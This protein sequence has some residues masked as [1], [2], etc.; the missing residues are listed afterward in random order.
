MKALHFGAG[1]IG[2]GFIGAALVKSGYS[3]VFADTAAELVAHINHVGSY[4]VHVVDYNS[5]TED[6]CGVTALLSGSKQCVAAISNVQIITTAVSV[7]HLEDVA[8]IIANGLKLRCLEGNDAPLNIICCENGV[9]AT[10]QLKAMVF[11]L[12]DASTVAWTNRYVGFADSAVDRIVPTASVTE[13]LDVAVEEFSEWKV[14]KS[15]IKGEIAPIEGMQLVDNLDA[16]INRKLFTLN[17]AHCATAYFGAMRGYEFIHEAVADGWI[18]ETV[19]QVIGQSSAALVVEFGIDELEQKTYAERI[20]SRFANPYIKD[21]V[22]RVARDPIRKLSAPL[23][24]T[25]PI[26]MAVKHNL[27]YSAIAVAAATALKYRADEDMQ[28]LQIATLIESMGLEK[29][30]SYITSITDPVVIATIAE[31]YR[32]VLCHP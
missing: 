32:S 21:T 30:V 9:R 14:E 19:R 11:K 5:H 7:R 27:P 4:K 15:A 1:K 28:S 25:T 24:F 8:P 12:L 20:L 16:A 18:E 31:A 26:N 13:G 29:T 17:T 10:S 22:S 2:R 3:V 6:V 23:Y